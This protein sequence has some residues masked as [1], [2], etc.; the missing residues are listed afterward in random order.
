MAFPLLIILTISLHDVWFFLFFRRLLLLGNNFE[1]V[2]P[3]SNTFDISGVDIEF[4]NAGRDGAGCTFS[5][6]LHS[7]II[8]SVLNLADAVEDFR[9]D[10]FFCLDSMVL[11]CV[12]GGICKRTRQTYLFQTIVSMI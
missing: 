2:T 3:F 9:L 7:A 11:K 8:A 12:A 4:S 1:D 10:G 6:P 5:E